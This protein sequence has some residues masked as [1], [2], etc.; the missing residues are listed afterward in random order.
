MKEIDLIKLG[1]ERVDETP[2][3][4]GSLKPWYYYSKDVGN[5]GFISNDSDSDEVMQ[6]NWS[7]DVLEGD[8][9]FTK[10][11]ELKTVIALLEKNKII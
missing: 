8:I 5:V 6:N 7:V 2:E 10:A 3:S 1:F 4:S 9:T 11:S